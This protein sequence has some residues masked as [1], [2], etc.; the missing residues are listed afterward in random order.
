MW[1]ILST[2]LTT[3][4]ML[5][6]NDNDCGWLRVLPARVAN[7]SLTTNLRCDWLILGAGYT[8]LSAARALADLRPD[9]QII[10]VDAQAAGEGASSRNSGY[11]VDSTL[12]DGHLSDS[13]LENYLDKYHLNQM[14]VN[15]VA[16][17]VERFQ[18]DCDWNACGKFH[19]T[20][21][22]RNEAKL[23]QFSSTLRSCEIDH[24]L[25]AGNAL[26]QRLGSRFYRMAVHTKG[27]VMLQPAKLAFGMID[28]LPENVQLFEQTP[29]LNWRQQ[30]T[31]YQLN[32][33]Q[34]VLHAANVLVCA[35]GF[36][37]SLG[38][39]KDR[40]FPLTL[41]ASL[42]RPL[43]ND[44]FQLIGSPAEWGVLSAQAMGATVR[45]TQDR[46]IMIRNTAEAWWPINMTSVQ[47]AE[48][49]Q[50]H[51]DGLHK[52]FPELP[53]DIIEYTWSGVTCISGNNGNIFQQFDKR[54]FIAGCY[55]GGGIGLATL[56]GEQLALK[57]VGGDSTELRAIERRPAPA[58][59][60]PQPFLHLGVKARL[61]RDRF[62]ARRER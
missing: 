8:G 31:G 29:I 3:K 51:A 40:A 38:L 20:A 16:N 10:L 41:T 22:A 14:G 53:K 34:G 54:L 24:E 61:S 2:F 18:I 43:S 15:A 39:V 52:R 44:E 7:P 46:R 9:E 49:Q 62:F 19:A 35:N 33:L 5:P 48:R 27:G 6:N 23:E 50:I 59:L 28:A 21:L 47:R 37:R 45:L 42:T 60:P 36:L 4:Q 11:L 25:L 13:G 26:H 1:T 57:A 58:W 32:T 12:N 56:F 17:L 55:N 30:G